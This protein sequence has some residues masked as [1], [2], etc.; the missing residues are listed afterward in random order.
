VPSKAP[1]QHT[2]V[3]NGLKSDIHAQC[4]APERFLSQEGSHRQSKAARTQGNL[5]IFDLMC[6]PFALSDGCWWVKKRGTFN[7]S[8]IITLNRKVNP[9]C[10]YLQLTT[11][12]SS[13][14]ML[15]ISV[16]SGCSCSGLSHHIP[17]DIEKGKRGSSP[18]SPHAAV[19]CKDINRR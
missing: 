11:S 16:D 1:L 5:H 14:S 6:G 19:R 15:T 10:L 3:I 18:H 12:K 9:F 7:H 4:H 2:D 13:G 8:H 17:K